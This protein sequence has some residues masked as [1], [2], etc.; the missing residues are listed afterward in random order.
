[1]GRHQHPK[2]K[3]RDLLTRRPMYNIFSLE[4]EPAFLTTGV[5]W[6]HWA[7]LPNGHNVGIT[8]SP[9]TD[10]VM[11]CTW[12]NAEIYAVSANKSQ[13]CYFD[14][15]FGRKNWKKFVSDYDV[16]YEFGFEE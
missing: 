4:W 11:L 10:E 6:G 8:F 15:Y 2:R 9:K 1:M 13:R 3:L 14:Q 5:Q 7:D 16:K 12:I